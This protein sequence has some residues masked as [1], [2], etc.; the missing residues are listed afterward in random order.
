MN[1]KLLIATTVITL[2][3][4]AAKSDKPAYQLF[5]EKGRRADYADLLKAAKNSDIILFGELHT[6]P[7]CHWLELELTRDLWEF[8]KEK[9]ILGAEMFERDNQLLLNEYLKKMIRK[10]DFEAEAKLWNNYKTDYAPLVDFARDKGLNFIAT[11]VPR[12]FAA[13]VNLKGFEGLDSI[14][15]LERGMM[16]PVPI[17]YDPELKSYKD[18]IK[19]AGD[20]MPGHI[21]DNLPK[22]QALKDATMANFIMKNGSDGMIFLHFNGSYHSENHEGIEW[23]IQ[24]AVKKLEVP[25]RVMTIASVEQDTIEDL[26]AENAGKATFIICVPSSMP[27]SQ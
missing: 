25:L 24:Q 10:K 22:A 16:A 5:N 27:H 1:K 26:N 4:M 2:F 17:K 11:N 12:R 7:I 14:N 19:S 13:I 3:L 20:G 9:L 18:I 6:N 23:Y 21:T 15:A 8:K